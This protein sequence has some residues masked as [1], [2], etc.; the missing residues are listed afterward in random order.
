M[1]LRLIFNLLILLGIFSAANAGD[2]NS[3]VIAEEDNIVRETNLPSAYQEFRYSFL[4]MDN[5]AKKNPLANFQFDDDYFVLYIAGGIAVAT[6]AIVLLN[7]PGQYENGIGQTN[8]G[9]II[10]GG[11]M[12]SLLVA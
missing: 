12:S 10:G 3:I 9:I 7:D 5:Q 11:I 2:N 8:T 4:N 1:K 6:T